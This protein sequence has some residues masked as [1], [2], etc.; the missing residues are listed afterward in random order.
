M[1]ST[2]SQIPVF[3][4]S[5]TPAEYVK[6]LLRLPKNLDDDS[7]LNNA[8]LGL[9]S[10]MAQFD[11]HMQ[12]CIQQLIFERIDVLTRLAIEESRLAG[13]PQ[14]IEHPPE[15]A[16]ILSRALKNNAV[17]LC[18][19]AKEFSD[20]IFFYVDEIMPYTEEL[21]DNTLDLNVNETVSRRKIASKISSILKMDPQYRHSS[22]DSV[23]RTGKRSIY[24]ELNTRTGTEGLS[25]YE[26]QQLRY[27]RGRAGS[28][29]VAGAWES[30]FDES[31]K[32]VPP[33]SEPVPLSQQRYVTRAA[34][35]YMA[36][37]DSD[38]YYRAPSESGTYSYLNT[39]HGETHP[40]GQS[41]SSSTG[42]SAPIAHHRSLSV[43]RRSPSRLNSSV[44]G[45]S[46][47]SSRYAGDTSVF[48]PYGHMRGIFRRSRSPG[49]TNYMQPR[50][51][52][53]A[54]TLYIP[55]AG[56]AGLRIPN[57]PSRS[58]SRSGSVY[59]APQSASPGMQNVPHG[60]SQSAARESNYSDPL[61]AGSPSTSFENERP[62]S[63]NLDTAAE[64]YASNTRKGIS[65]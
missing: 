8:I 35:E 5:M 59:S 42:A 58:M 55:P 44:G 52:S 31:G 60:R 48:S 56:W 65:A 10:I 18:N 63:Q 46:T 62:P 54:R 40:D 29:S 20:D 33:E 41:F 16:Q 24:N 4:E 22:H 26:R 32:M 36:S 25:Y 51:Q 38:S 61:Y 11:V 7:P 15:I 2:A 49:R 3:T 64:K 34:S 45:A 43:G 1:N 53:P 30:L 9:Q 57:S 50:A 27:G 28:P 13:I 12:H 17:A 47:T 21:A 37:L 23:T 14:N 39:S 6:E 19:L